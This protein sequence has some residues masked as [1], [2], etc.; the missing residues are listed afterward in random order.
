MFF[1]VPF[2]TELASR[3]PVHHK[4]LPMLPV[5][6][7]GRQVE[8]AGETA[9]EDATAQA[10]QLAADLLRRVLISTTSTLAAFGNQANLLFAQIAAA[11]AFDRMA[12]QA[13]SLSGLG[14][15][16]F[17][18]FFQQ[19]SWAAAWPWSAPFQ[20]PAW[21]SPAAIP[22]LPVNLWANPWSA[23]AEAFSAWANIWQPATAQRGPLAG[24][25]AERPPFT[26][27]LSLPGWTWNVTL[28]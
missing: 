17:G 13:A 16:F 5:S 18:P 26:A 11:L 19:Q 14:W 21:Y 3:G 8:R 27:M 28:R 22:P 23:F 12:R 15:S 9:F 7:G 25:A 24:A 10:C 4:P 2:A 20:N 6:R 1:F